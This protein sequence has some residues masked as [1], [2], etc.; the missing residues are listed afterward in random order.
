MHYFLLPCFV[1]RLHEYRRIQNSSNHTIS[2]KNARTAQERLGLWEPVKSLPQRPPWRRD[3]RDPALQSNHIANTIT[4]T[5]FSWTTDCSLALHARIGHKIAQL[6]LCC[7]K[8]TL[9]LFASQSTFS[10]FNALYIRS[11]KVERYCISDRV[12]QYL[13]REKSILDYKFERYLVGNTYRTGNGK[14]E[15]SCSPP[16][17][18]F[19]FNRILSVSLP[20]AENPTHK[21]L[22]SSF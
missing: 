1:G 19:C 12:L 15:S 17:S 7:C 21:S 8:N 22:V 5:Y 2:N 18:P 3:V 16:P 6:G 11:K 4:P 10:I 20:L 13:S 14:Q 9:L